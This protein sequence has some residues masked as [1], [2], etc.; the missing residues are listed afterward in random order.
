M[1]LI[2]SKN[3]FKLIRL[4][5]KRTRQ[6]R[7]S[8]KRTRQEAL[9]VL[10]RGLPKDVEDWA[11]SVLMRLRS[12]NPSEEHLV[13]LAKY[14]LQCSDFKDIA[15]HYKRFKYLKNVEK[16]ISQFKSF[17]DFKKSVSSLPTREY[18]LEVLKLD[19]TKFK[20]HVDGLLNI[21]LSTKNESGEVN[22]PQ[23]K[24]F[25]DAYVG[26]CK[27]NK[28]FLL[29]FSNFKSF[30]D[31][32]NF[33]DVN[34]K[35][36]VGGE[37]FLGEA[38]YV[39][40]GDYAKVYYADSKEK[41]QQ[42]SAGYGW[43][44]GWLSNN[45]YYNYRLG[46]SERCFYFVKFPDRSE[47]QNNYIV[48]HVTK[49]GKYHWSSTKNDNGDPEISK[50]NLIDKFYELKYL[51][52]DSVFKY[53][54]VSDEE[55]KFAKR[56]SV[57]TFVGF[58]YDEKSRYIEFGHNLN[59][60][61][62]KFLDKD[63]KSKYINTLNEFLEPLQRE[64]I[65]D[66]IGLMSSYENRLERHIIPN[67]K[68]CISRDGVPPSFAF[69]WAK[70]NLDPADFV[71]AIS[72]Y[73]AEYSIIPAWVED[74]VEE[75]PGRVSDGICSY[76]R[77]HGDAPSFAI[78]WAKKN[79]DPK[80]FHDQL[81][82]SRRFSSSPVNWAIDYCMDNGI[83]KSKEELLNEINN[84]I[85]ISGYP[86][87]W[88]KDWAKED[89][90]R[91]SD[92]I[93]DR[94]AKI[95][96]IS[97]G[98]ID[99]AL[100]DIRRV[101]RGLKSFITKEEKVPI[102]A[103]PW[104]KE[105]LDPASIINGINECIVKYGMPPEWTHDWVK[106]DP[107]RV[108]DGI[109]QYLNKPKIHKLSYPSWFE[110][111]TTLTE[112]EYY[113]YMTQ[114]QK[115]LNAPQKPLEE[116]PVPLEEKPDSLANTRVKLIRVASKR[117]KLIRV[118][119]KRTKLQALNTL[120]GDKDILGSLIE[121]NQDE[122]HLPYLAKFYIQIGNLEEL[123]SSY[124][125]FR[126]INR[127]EKDISQFRTF[128]EFSDSVSNEKSV[129]YFSD[130]LSMDETPLKL[131]VDNLIQILGTN[132]D[133]VQVSSF[134]KKY[135]DIIS[136]QAIDQE[137]NFA[138]F[139]DLEK[140]VDDNYESISGEFEDQEENDLDND[141]L[142]INYAKN[143]NDAKRLSNGFG[144]C[145]GWEHDNQ[146]Y[147][148]RLGD[149]ERSFYFVR[150]KNRDIS[151]KSSNPYIVVQRLNDGELRWTN[152]QN[153]NGDMLSTEDEL[154][155]LF[156]ELKSI[157][158]TEVFKHVPLTEDERK[159]CRSVNDDQFENFNYEEKSA[160]ISFGHELSTD[161]FR[162]CD[163][164]QRSGYINRLNRFLPETV[165]DSI[166][167]LIQNDKALMSTYNKRV[168]GPIRKIIEDQLRINCDPPSWAI[169]WIMRNIDPADFEE[170][171]ISKVRRSGDFPYWCRDWCKDNID[172][173]D[174]IDV[175][176]KHLSN[177]GDECSP[178]KWTGRWVNNNAGLF[179]DIIERY[180][181]GYG[182]CPQWATKW[183]KENLDPVNFKE[184]ITNYIR[185]ND[186]PP[187]W[188][189]GYCID[190]G[191]GRSKEKWLQYIESELTY[192]DEPP[193]W[194]YG[195][196]VENGIGKS[197]EEYIKFFNDKILNHEITYN[198]RRFLSQDPSIVIDG[199]N[200]YLVR[201]KKL[202]KWSENW[203]REDPSR[204]IDGINLVIEDN[205]YHLPKF[206][207]LWV[208]EDLS[209]V[210]I[211]ID[212]FVKEYGY[213]PHWSEEWFQKN[214]DIESLSTV[215]N[216]EVAQYGMPQS[217]ALDWVKE[218]LSRVH[219]G[220]VKYVKKHH[221]PMPLF[222]SYC[223]ENGVGK[224]KEDWIYDLNGAVQYD[225]N[226]FKKERYSVYKF[227][228]DWVLEDP[229]RVIDGIA[230][231][232]L[233]EGVPSDWS[234]F[235]AESNKDKLLMYINNFDSWTLK[236]NVSPNWKDWFSDNKSEDLPIPSEKESIIPEVDE[237]TNEVTANRKFKLIK[238]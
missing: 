13:Y 3:S 79:L 231:Y 229:S 159:Y 116:K 102:W 173:A 206:I 71:N 36:V 195:Y 1:K 6:V 52:F 97:N 125:R 39:S 99:W 108:I 193:E 211:G 85:R 154:K 131:H 15:L 112:Q 43:C 81:V 238:L 46:D 219:S 100:E 134:Y 64:Y 88:A 146:Y 168:N 56:V 189:V 158:F 204:V 118:A 169:R 199:I 155:E 200:Q 119:S 38:D 31:L 107:T 220:L 83:G 127:P 20:S 184:E 77:S 223:I 44:I 175:I 105:N 234:K 4:S 95:G 69:D 51:D 23:V 236:Y 213:P 128:Q 232:I 191:I 145:V 103:G 5:S 147:N 164:E 89:P 24:T 214:Y 66:D 75:D 202:P 123:A 40:V 54:P 58:D 32:E 209:R 135:L 233:R 222:G 144:W 2:K 227:A 122:K 12:I 92:G 101:E 33:V 70:Y 80:D 176:K 37:G 90:S 136:D 35:E 183:S 109:T 21:L 186:L 166:L 9:N 215:I 93:N 60:H 72:D 47:E 228:E 196:C 57:Q 143:E 25:Y 225:K 45:Q 28:E 14:Y 217:W 63:Q 221:S 216:E 165:D 106:E 42:L 111:N 148:Y 171:I 59:S 17:D 87:D 142:T 41:A 185:D 16:D 150:F 203:V 78:D 65:K 174:H 152:S 157:N 187:E 190:N 163:K 19:K 61:Q 121:I 86:P 207:E 48:I 167:D 226:I 62:F 53:V 126:Y 26:L 133:I 8:S 194:A 140:F 120:N 198:D 141:L 179:R 10:Y 94:I 177:I 30:S 129:K 7:L 50:E 161:Q 27:D 180:I 29:E 137:F 34:S 113:K 67:I 132:P 160:Y 49:D 212:N 162:L 96:C 84:H 210:S 82:K 73:I 156:P 235:W 201:H 181:R 178:P 218:D 68:E 11:D 188:C 98:Y 74:W 104:A 114:T 151:D 91:V 197:K 208:K 110:D 205:F 149:E 182:D 170:A 172:P 153:N 237:K 138:T 130:A 55:R 22:I 230:R 192:E 18:F 224:D 139:S 124:R 76:I 117:T 115:P